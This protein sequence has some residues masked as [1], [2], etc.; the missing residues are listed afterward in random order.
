MINNKVKIFLS[1]KNNKKYIDIEVLSDEATIADYCEALDEFFL[2]ESF[3]RVRS[4]A[5][6]CEGCNVCCQERIPLTIIDALRLRKKVAPDLSME[7]FLKRY[8]YITVTEDIVD[9]T[10]PNGENSSCIFLNEVTNKCSH[11]SE[12]PFVCRTYICTPL[13]TKAKKLRDY[14]LNSGEDELVFLWQKLREDDNYIVHEAIDFDYQ[15][16]EYEKNPW[17]GVENYQD[18]LI[19]DL[20]PNSLWLELRS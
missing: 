12:R 16:L 11:Y 8:T 20:V 9:I 13:T 3:L 19:K 18:L 7:E 10:L 4:S 17:T 2:D 5:S 6:K 14:I 15:Q 1:S